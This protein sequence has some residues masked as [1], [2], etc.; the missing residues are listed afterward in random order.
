ML[1][2]SLAAGHA[3]AASD[4]DVAVQAVRPLDAAQKIAL[5]G[6][7]AAAT[8]RAVDLIDLRR[9]GEPLLGQ[10]VAHGRRVLGSDEA[11]AR[12]V[13]RHLLDAADFLP[14]A[15]RLLAERRQAWTGR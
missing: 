15:N 9:A 8:G 7:I 10:I 4:V 3:S 6:D 12:L 1:F 13:S 2:G 11:F 14:L 5:V